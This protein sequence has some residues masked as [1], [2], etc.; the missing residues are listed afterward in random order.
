MFQKSEVVAKLEHRLNTRA[1][2]EKN[3]AAYSSQIL[4]VHFGVIQ[5]GGTITSI[6]PDTS[7]G[8]QRQKST[9]QKLSSRIL[10]SKN[11]CF[12]FVESTVTGVCLGQCGTPD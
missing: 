4:T 11:R 12:H 5:L 9:L 7:S 2:W 10:R 8:T 1:Q 3:R 6:E